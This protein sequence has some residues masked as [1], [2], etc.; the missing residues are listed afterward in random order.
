MTK[1]SDK[2][3][4]DV[5]NTFSLVFNQILKV[6]SSL[7]SIFAVSYIIGYFRLNA[8]YE[9]FD[10]KWI[11][12]NLSV[13]DFIS[14]SI[15]TTSIF[16]IFLILS[17]TDIAEGKS[18]KGFYY[19][20]L[21]TISITIIISLFVEIYLRKNNIQWS[22][23]LLYIAASQWAISA[24]IMLNIIIQL[25]KREK[26]E[27][28]SNLVLSLMFVIIYGFYSSP[29]ALGK[30]E[31]Y[32]DSN[33]SISEL[34]IVYLDEDKKS[35]WRLLHSKSELF[36]LVKIDSIDS[37]SPVLKIVKHNSINFIKGIENK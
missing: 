3:D 8:Y 29:N 7:I 34:P 25:L 22:I 28:N 17:L 27:W 6:V 9:C 21:I 16:I 15:F 20:L 13:L 18:L 10:A 23:N 30:S 2:F 36:Y 31:G 32:R 35:N 24:S 26:F 11:I 37:N 14:A 5:I 4:K 12:S 19:F 1:I 33:Y